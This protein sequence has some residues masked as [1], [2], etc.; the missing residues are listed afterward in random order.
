M[1]GTHPFRFSSLSKQLL[2]V[3]VLAVLTLFAL[4]GQV[5]SAQAPP[6]LNETTK[7][8]ASDTA[9][10]DQFGS[11]VSVSG[12]RMMVGA[13]N[14]NGISGAMYVFERSNATGMWNEDATLGCGQHTGISVSV[15]G[16]TALAG[17]TAGRPCVFERDDLTGNWNQA[18]QPEEF[19]RS[20]Y[21]AVS[22]RR[23]VGKD[24][25]AAYASEQDPRSGTWLEREQLD[26]PT[27]G[28]GIGEV[29]ISGG[30]VLVGF[31]NGGDTL[32]P[33]VAR[34][35]GR[36]GGTGFW[37]LL[38]ELRASDEEVDD[39]FGFSVSLSGN[40]AVIGAPADDDGGEDSGSVYVFERN[41]GT[42]AWSEVAKLAADDAQ[43][44]ANFG[45]S[46]FVLGNRLLV[47]AP[48]AGASQTG[49]VYDYNRDSQS[50]NWN[51]VAK[52]L[53]SDGEAGD[54]FGDSVAISGGIAVVG[55]PQDDGDIPAQ[56]GDPSS[57]SDFGAVYVF[58]E[59]GDLAVV[60]QP[61]DPN[62]STMPVTLTFDVITST[63]NTTLTT[64]MAGPPP[65]SG[66]QPGNGC[67]T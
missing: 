16:D 18:P 44:F 11:A 53:P 9:M 63:G 49:A 61:L 37:V 15:S 14:H 52:L 64:S 43:A 41:S 56:C 4:D 39:Q 5:A 28:E 2:D 20:R 66:F 40:T 13:P 55:S 1:H 47:G 21:V 7:L 27:G 45:D 22:G 54:R 32:A 46:V 35:H 8:R 17:A 34:I 62:T 26:N 48:N 19:I 57:C 23:V 12:S 50:G 36:E 29:S 30:E 51:L 65:P 60:E 59:P 33:G 42:G 10:F 3:G 6:T 58:E 38:A 67:A 24:G 31:I 25:G